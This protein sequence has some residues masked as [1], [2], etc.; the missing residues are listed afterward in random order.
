MDTGINMST[1]KK[2]IALALGGGGAAG[3]FEC[4]VL[5]V[6]EKAGF[7]PDLIV[8]CSTG[9]I[10]AAGFAL[11]KPVQEYLDVTKDFS[12]KLIFPFNKKLLVKPH[13][14]TSISSQNNLQKIMYDYIGD[15][16]LMTVKFR[17]MLWPPVYVMGKK[18]FLVKGASLMP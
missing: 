6:F 8:G 4:G 16:T 13:A 3:A 10:Q 2:K 9:A 5:R 12:T 17:S 11:G 18:C 14:T 7:F 15:A 1:N